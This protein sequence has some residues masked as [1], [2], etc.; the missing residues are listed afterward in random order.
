VPLTFR[1]SSAEL[2]DDTFIVTVSGEADALA[3]PELQRQLDALAEDGARE[4]IVDL[5]RVP[6]LDSTILGVLLRTA[7]RV[8]A[9]GG[10]VVLI[11]DDPRVLRTFEISGL[12]SSFRF[13]RSLNA[14]VDR[15]LRDVV[16]Q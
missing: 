12:V 11:S 15:V 16:R 7:R 14:A 2:T 10:D 8:R 3:A 4:L 1:L 9:D 5:L 13:E 6:F